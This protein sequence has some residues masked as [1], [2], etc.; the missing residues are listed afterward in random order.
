MNKFMPGTHIGGVPCT[1]IDPR[2]CFRGDRRTGRLCHCKCHVIPAILFK[3][4]DFPIQYDDPMPEADVFQFE[5]WIGRDD[6][7]QAAA[8][9]DAHGQYRD[10]VRHM[11][12]R[13]PIRYGLIEVMIENLMEHDPMGLLKVLVDALAYR[14]EIEKE[15]RDAQERKDPKSILWN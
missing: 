13:S 3:L 1:H 8:Y 12:L 15:K 7:D 2:D 4:V 14:E 11:I 9:L 6:L 10:Q 5:R